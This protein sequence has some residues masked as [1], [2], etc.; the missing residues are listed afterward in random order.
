MQPRSFF[1]DLLTPFIDRMMS[2]MSSS[3]SLGQLLD[4]FRFA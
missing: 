1:C 3:L 2:S 4:S